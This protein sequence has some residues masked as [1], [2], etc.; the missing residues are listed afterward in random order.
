MTDPGAT[1][2]NTGSRTCAACKSDN[3]GTA[4]F[5]AACGAM[6]PSQHT[7]SAASGAATLLSDA[8]DHLSAAQWEEAALAAEAV[9][10]FDPGSAEAHN[11]IARAR[12]KQGMRNA[13]LVHAERAVELAPGNPAYEADVA[14]ARGEGAARSLT[15]AL[16]ASAA[17]LIIFVTLIF[18]ASSRQK[19]ALPA[20]DAG[21]TGT[22]G[23]APKP[24]TVS[25]YPQT[26][27]SPSGS[28]QPRLP[29]SPSV[30]TSTVPRSG[31][32]PDDS[33]PA[34]A[35][36]ASA[37][38][39]L[40]P[41]PVD[42]ALKPFPA[43]DSGA[44][45]PKER[46]EAPSATHRTTAAPQAQPGGTSFGPAAGAGAAVTTP[47]SPYVYTEPPVMP[48][49]EPPVSPGAPAADTPPPSPPQQHFL[50][51]NYPDAVK[52]YVRIVQANPDNGAAWQQLAYSYQQ[53]N[54]RGEA[55]QAYREAIAAYNRQIEAG[56]GG[57]VARRGIRA[58]ERA[59]QMLAVR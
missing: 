49:A 22:V 46:T 6:L 21:D 8:R 41:A 7:T 58:C 42:Q 12:L 34:P 47:A 31:P 51:R 54:M 30:T 26:F 25:S 15:P 23:T 38:A 4:R 24:P 28:A 35:P 11:I 57:D 32:L 48:A 37:V 45:S 3:V 43:G 27:P 5:C 1:L 50:D 52:G 40:E 19:G 16:V 56:E 2:R 29:G 18:I 53:L 33:A 20:P 9:L 36:S 14:L 10:A 13:A 44:A 59:L 17:A 55:A 39:G